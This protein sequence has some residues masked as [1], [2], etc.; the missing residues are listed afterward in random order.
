VPTSAHDEAIEVDEL[1]PDT[2][3]DA[4][5]APAPPLAAAPALPAKT[6]SGKGAGR[7]VLFALLAVAIAAL[8]WF[9]R[10]LL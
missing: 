4:P 8:A 3:P 1:A 6:S 9:G 5:A 2:E 7:V 10:K